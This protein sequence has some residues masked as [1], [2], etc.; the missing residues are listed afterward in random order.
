MSIES[1]LNGDETASSRGWQSCPGGQLVC[2]VGGEQ[3]PPRRWLGRE[4]GV[5][6]CRA[7]VGGNGGI[8]NVWRGQGGLVSCL[9]GSWG[10]KTK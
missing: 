4:D 9:Q 2:H 3:H 10:K 7:V 5:Q 8:G 6:S 1:V